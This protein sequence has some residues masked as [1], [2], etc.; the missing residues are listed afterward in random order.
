MTDT[1]TAGP[2]APPAY[3]AH[4]DGYADR[5]L[6]AVL[7][8][9]RTLAMVGA[10]GNWKRPSFF[11]MKYLQK[12]GYRVIPV[13]PSRAGDEILGETVYPSL[14][15]VPDRFEMVDI[16]RASDAAYAVT[17]E[18]IANRDA[19]GIEVIWMQLGVRNDAAAELAEAAGLTVIMDRCPKIEYGRLSGELSWCGVNSRII[20]AKT[21]RSPKR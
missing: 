18:A 17:Q 4:H 21:L 15:D 3:L 1:A 5:T 8:K 13:N 2:A 14:S 6:R 7:S 20:T 9:V 16:F 10:S 19:K 11:A 12:R